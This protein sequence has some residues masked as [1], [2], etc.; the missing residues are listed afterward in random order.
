MRQS[1]LLASATSRR[2]KPT[3]RGAFFLLC[4]PSLVGCVLVLAYLLV[5]LGSFSR[6]QGVL[7]P[8]STMPADNVRPQR[9][10]SMNSDDRRR[11]AQDNNDPEDADEACPFRNSTIY[12]RVYVYPSPGEEEWKGSTLSK[13]GRLLNNSSWPWLEVDRRTRQAESN[14]YHVSSQHAQFAT[15][16]LVRQIIAHPQSCLR[17]DDPD[18]AALFLVP[19]LPSVEFHAGVRGPP[20]THKTSLYA[21]A[22]ADA[23]DGDY[24]GWKQHFGLT[25]KYWKRRSGSDHILVFSEPLQ[26][27][28]HPKNK[29]GSYHFI[30][31]QRQLD[32]PIVISVELSTTFI[33][34]HPACAEKNILMPYPIT[35]GRYFNGEWTRQAA[36]LLTNSTYGLPVANVIPDDQRPLTVFYR[37]GLHGS[38]TA[39]R[40][41]LKKDAKCSETWSLQQKLTEDYR[42]G[43]RLGTFCPC[44]GGDTASAKRMFDAVLAGCIPV[45]LSHDFVWPLSDEIESISNG[46][47][48]LQ[49]DFSIR[50]AAQEHWERKYSQTCRLSNASDISLFE[51]LEKVPNDEIERLRKGLKRAAA[52]YSYYP[53]SLTP[54][55]ENPLRD[56]IL[57]TGGAARALVV[58]LEERA[59][60]VKW[61]ACQQELERAKTGVQS[62]EPDQ[63]QC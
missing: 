44:P 22:I 57:P 19:Y 10:K 50:W 54:L 11:S 62:P 33:N 8:P 17:T 28:T 29:R 18:K 51:R 38:C 24:R 52:R 53:L 48:L 2:K 46:N 13:E 36:A 37:A 25:D 7:V 43:M 39:L 61:P 5:L 35:D 31:T 56:D 55:V 4:K 59:G 3:I 45:I 58:A 15:E 27:L 16:L 9:E 14:H 41:S 30:H 21:Q 40:L 42:L 1:A 23:I 12:R 6:Q 32:P 49:S 60:G 47:T 34:M 20:P 26:G 63:F